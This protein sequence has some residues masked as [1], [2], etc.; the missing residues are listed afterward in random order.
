V[1]DTGVLLCV[2]CDNEAAV[3][4]AGFKR[5]AE[6]AARAAAKVHPPA[7]MAAAAAVQAS[8]ENKQSIPFVV[9]L[10]WVMIAWVLFNSKGCTGS[11]VDSFDPH[12]DDMSQGVGKYSY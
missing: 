12:P 1:Q 6:I 8:Q 2:L 10:V 9:I 4:A 7:P 11:K 3:R 5:D